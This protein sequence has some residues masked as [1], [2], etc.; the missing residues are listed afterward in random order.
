[1]SVYDIQ[2]IELELHTKLLNNFKFNKFH[3]NKFL[4]FSAIIFLIN[5]QIN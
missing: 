2:P 4:R 3:K 1:M 5:P